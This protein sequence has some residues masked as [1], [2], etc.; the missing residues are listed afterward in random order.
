MEDFLSQ[1]QMM[2][3]FMQDDSFKAFISHPKIQELFK[4]PEFRE[5]AKTRDF[6]KIGMHPKFSTALKDPEVA[7]LASKI[8]I[9][10]AGLS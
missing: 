4:D 6:S 1:L 10:K 5:V 9:F 8:D 7:R 2:Q 3:H